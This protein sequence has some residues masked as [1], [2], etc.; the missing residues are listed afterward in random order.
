MKIKPCPFC[1]GE[2]ELWN[3]NIEEYK[4][5]AVQCK[6][7]GMVT[8]YWFDD[9]LAVEQWNRREPIGKIVEQL[10][11]YAKESHIVYIRED[12]ECCRGW[13]EALEFAIEIVRQGGQND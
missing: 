8:P 1:G 7:C 13:Y 3:N 9:E 10:E 2:A 11:Y 6:N 5:Y 4:L 12:E